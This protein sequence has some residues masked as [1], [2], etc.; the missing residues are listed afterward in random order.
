MAGEMI[1]GPDMTIAAENNISRYRHS[2]SYTSVTP[3]VL[4]FVHNVVCC[5]Y[6]LHTVDNDSRLR[7]KKD[8]VRPVTHPLSVAMDVIVDTIRSIL[9]QLTRHGIPAVTPFLH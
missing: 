4:V 2:S 3:F 7:C 5:H 6:P 1:F 9:Q 8:V